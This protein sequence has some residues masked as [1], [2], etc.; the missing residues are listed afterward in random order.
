MERT[1]NVSEFILLGL[2]QNMELQKFSF[3]VFL[4]VY[5]VTVAGNLLIVITISTSRAL[6]SPMYFFLS[7]LSLLDGCCSSS[8]TPK[9]LANTLTV[10]KVISFRG[11]MTQVFA[12]HLFG[13]AEIIL[14]T[15]MAYDR[16]VAICKPL[17]Y[18]T[19][20]SRQVCNLLVGVAWAGAFVHATIQ[21]LCTVWLP[22]CGPNVIDHFMCDLN[23]LLKLVCMDTHTLGLFVAANSGFICL[24]NFLPLM[25]SYAVILYSLRTYSLEGRRKALST[26]VSH[27]T[28]VILFFVPCIFVYLRPVRTFSVDKA[29]A[30]FYTMITPMLNPLIYT[31]RNAEVKNAL[32]KLWIK[33]GKRK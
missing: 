29:V 3:V 8:M 6:G 22:F 20:M 19:I 17:Y 7:Y 12:E 30:V 13:A 2:T 4:M 26:C 10:R 9:M 14:L 15:V 23:P 27:I 31:L 28:V 11:C 18:T 25:V 5:L 16:Y 21:L 32:K 33:S 1:N 24:L